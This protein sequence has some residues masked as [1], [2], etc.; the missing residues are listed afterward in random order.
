VMCSFVEHTSDRSTGGIPPFP[1]VV[2][3]TLRAGKRQ[4][5]QDLDTFEAQRVR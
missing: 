3:I 2:T 5:I 1:L 4:A